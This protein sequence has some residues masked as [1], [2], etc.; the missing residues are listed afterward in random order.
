[1]SDLHLD[2]KL[3]KVR[4]LLLDVDGVL[5]DGSIVLG[6]VNLELKVF[7]IQDGL[8]IRLAKA[9]GIEIGI[10]T[11][12]TSDAVALRAR[13][14]G[15][16]ILCQGRKNKLQSYQEILTDLRLSDE[17]VCYMGD[18]LPD[19]L[20]IQ[21]AGVGVAV[22]NGCDEVKHYADYI[23]SRSGGQG[24]VREVIEML[25]KSQGHWNDLVQ[26]YIG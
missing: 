24:A 15:I 6:S 18:D 23:T 22:A 14:L 16:N 17:A 4:L 7:N 13:E 1:M 25:L 12:R 26:N 5:T 10:I 9:G 21:K 2:K 8:G 19:L 20:L 11:G 3:Q